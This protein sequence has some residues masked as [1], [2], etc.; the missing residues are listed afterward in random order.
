MES[1]NLRKIKEN[2]NLE[3]KESNL[4]F[5]YNYFYEINF[6]IT[7]NFYSRRSYRNN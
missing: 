2:Q 3:E 5:D 6:I 1:K 7:S 4:T